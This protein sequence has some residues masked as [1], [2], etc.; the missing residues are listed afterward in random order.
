[1]STKEEIKEKLLKALPYFRYAIKQ[2]RDEAP[3]DHTVGLAVVYYGPSGGKV[4]ARF[5][6]AEFFE[7]IAVLL[8]APEFTQADEDNAKALAFLSQLGLK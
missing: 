2:A 1:M 6:A 5:P 3:A 8:D 7:D 4:T